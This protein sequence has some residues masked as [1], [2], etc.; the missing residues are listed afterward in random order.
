MNRLLPASNGNRFSVYVAWDLKY[1]SID[2][3]F[4]EIK[5]SKERYSLEVIH[6]PFESLTFVY[7]SPDKNTDFFAKP[8]MKVYA[9]SV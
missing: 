8:P 7:P 6:E 1:S 4:F 9:H 5:V 2:F 3:R